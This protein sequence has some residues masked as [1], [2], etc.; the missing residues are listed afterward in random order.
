MFNQYTE[1]YWYALYTKPR[2]EF[3]A[4][5]QISSLGIELYLPTITRLKQ[6]SD[7]KKKVT[8]P[9]LRSYIFINAIEKERITCLDLQPIVNCLME[10]SRAAIIPNNQIENL[11]HFIKAENEYFVYEGIVNGTIIRIKEGPFKDI[12]GVVVDSNHCKAIGVTIPLLNR[13]VLT[14]FS[15]TSVFE[16]IS[17]PEKTNNSIKYA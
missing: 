9:L 17:T 7:R 14:Y 11:R 15:N 13:T 2:H 6:W 8:E 4:A 1:K 5:E 16:V 10:G 3:K 12:Q